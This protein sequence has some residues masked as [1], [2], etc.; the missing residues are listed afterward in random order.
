MSATSNPMRSLAWMQKHCINQNLRGPNLPP[1]PFL[2]TPSPSEHPAP[3]LPRT[4]L[5]VRHERPA[6]P[7]AEQA[8]LAVL[9]ALLPPLADPLGASLHG[10]LGLELRPPPVVDE[11]R[12]ALPVP[13]TA[14][15]GPDPVIVAEGEVVRAAEVL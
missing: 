7:V 15:L 12:G 8:F 6:R 4:K 13:M 9:G 2:P 10:V 5:L 11:A 14:A 1:E 3:W